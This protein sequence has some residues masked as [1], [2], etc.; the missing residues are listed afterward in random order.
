MKE[1]LI[2]VWIAA[3]VSLATCAHANEILEA[4]WDEAGN[5][6][7]AQG[8]P[9]AEARRIFLNMDDIDVF[10]DGPGT[11]VY[12]LKNAGDVY[13]RRAQELE[14]TG[15]REAVVRAY[16]RANALYTA[17]RFPA[18]FTPAREAAYRLQIETYLKILKHRGIT[19]QVV[20]IPFEGRQIVGHFYPTGELPAPVVVWSGGTDGW[21]M[22]GLDFK[23]TLLGEGFS[24]FA[25]D[26][27]GTGESQHDLGPDSERVYDRVVEYLRERDDVV[28]GGI[29]LYFGSFSGVFAVHL[30][31][32]NPD[33]AAAVNHSGGIH[34][35]FTQHREGGMQALP[36][37]TTSMGMRA[38]ATIHAFGVDPR[39]A[40][41][42]SDGGG[43]LD[44]SLIERMSLV[45]QGLLR[46]TPDQAP[47]LSI[48]G[49]ADMLMPIE[50][51]E[52]L[53]ASGVRSDGL[54]YE[55]DRHMAWEHAHDHRP[56]M[57]A[58]LK[59]HVGAM[60]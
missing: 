7:V 53:I 31:L 40:F 18:L 2:K 59:E 38:A 43:E 11:W 55:G 58:W 46:E 27:P 33:V 19:M 32:T 56:K 26:M 34:K 54:I 9:E 30:A 20:E 24:V 35:T 52:I 60:R 1:T 51:W 48:Y 14:L 45:H 44:F 49:T 6:L 42:A 36:P 3:S 28:A 22:A 47:L 15:D 5:G 37:L 23:E 16:R 4:W 57:I 29:A 41:P 50:D 13:R 12:E 10:A 21:K 8:V 39:T 25:M 17:A